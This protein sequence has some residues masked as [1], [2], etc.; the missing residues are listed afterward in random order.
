MSNK[1]VKD[2]SKLL[3]KD[4]VDDDELVVRLYSRNAVY[5]N[6]I[7]QAVVFPTTSDDVSVIVRYCY[8]NNICIYPQGSSSELVGS[9][10]PRLDGIVISFQRM[11][12]ILDASII[13]SYVVVQ[14]GVRLIDL[15][16]YLARMGYMFPVDPA[17]IRI[18]TVGGAINTGAG[19]MQGAKYGTMKDWVLELEIVIPNEGGSIIRIGSKTAKCR[20]GYDLV[21]LIVGSE[22][23]LALVTEA[24]L[25]I[26]PIPDNIV[27]AA[28]FF[29]SLND[30]M[31][32]VIDL[33]RDGF[34][35]LMMEFVDADTVA[36]ASET[37]GSRITGSGHLLIVAVD[38]PFEATKRILRDIK[39]YMEP[40]NASKIYD[41]ASLAEADEM[42][43]LDIR[44]NAYPASI[45]IASESRK[46]PM[47]RVM[48]Y[49]EDISVPPS[50]LVEAIEKLKGLAER[51]DLPMCLAGHVSDGNI[52]PVIWIEEGDEEKK[53]ALL[54]M[55]TDIMR[56]SVELG[57]T[58][59]SEHGIGLTKRERLVKE[60]ERK[61][62][63]EAIGLMKDIK[64]IFDPKGI[65][66][67][68]KVFLW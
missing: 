6:G 43:L 44:R 34:N 53:E 28:A 22:G 41:A 48:V 61:G 33:K 56:I 17:S 14:P 65:L 66:N 18:A 15:N 10:T 45:K 51:Y 60:M 23:T 8:K 32:T 35:A 42:G 49:V 25:K 2:L 7:A 59:S 4:K 68:D 67:P 58:M 50:R 54:A 57:G 16:N 1:V 9:S 36:M 52:H 63:L 62:S 39:S 29:D 13:D 5:M 19:G 64:R 27:V 38:T 11:N 3:G 40:N 46:D 30:L 26:T 21:R 31:N 47:S 20:Q 37:I 12:R 24:T 55:A